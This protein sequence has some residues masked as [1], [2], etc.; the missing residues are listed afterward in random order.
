[1]IEF[2]CPNC[3]KRFKVADDWAGKRARCKTCGSSFLVPMA[4]IAEPPPV[5]RTQPPS[6]GTGASIAE[7][8][9]APVM[10]QPA[11]TRQRIVVS[12][13]DSPL[14]TK[15]SKKVEPLDKQRE[16]E[17]RPPMRIR[18]LMADAEQMSRVFAHFPLIRIVSME[19]NPP[20]KYRIEYNVRGLARGDDGQPIYR[21][22]HLVE[23]Q[24]TRDYPRQSPKCR[25]LTPI[26]HPNFDSSI[27]CVGDHWTAAEKLVDLVVRIGEMI[28][29]Q[30]YNIKSPLDGEA[31]MWA[32]LNQAVL[33]TD[34]R[35]L[36]PPEA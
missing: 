1:M 14:M 36:V 5:P 22:R 16:V 21:D 20:D 35:S 2:C 28:A 23:I 10:Q 25:I 17:R 32:D 11:E 18:R 12:F 9:P 7:P 34:K 4:S 30:A 6:P 8:P 27:I 33:P 29:Y 24:L 15:L 3:G 31:A 19:G 13:D 26:F